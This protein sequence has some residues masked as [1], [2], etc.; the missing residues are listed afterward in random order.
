MH[1]KPGCSDYSRLVK[2]KHLT[3]IFETHC[4]IVKAITNKHAWAPKQYLYID[5]NAGPGEI[6]DYIGSPI[7]F[8]QV[9]KKLDVNYQVL[10]IEKDND[11]F[12]ALED[13][14]QPYRP[15]DNIHL[16]HNDHEVI[17][18]DPPFIKRESYG[19]L[20]S[21]PNGIK[22]FPSI[23]VLN[24]FIE[25]FPYID[26]LLH[27]GCTTFKRVDGA[28][29]TGIRANSYLLESK[30]RRYI[31]EPYTHQQWTFIFLTNYG[32]FDKK[33][34]NIGFYGHNEPRYSEIC[35]KIFFTAEE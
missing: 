24:Q 16:Y 19:L 20:Y 17:L 29:S 8:L 2:Q 5:A 1:K 18:P 10:F 9:A 12:L 23:K 22:G 31:R 25:R 26:I 3:N 33:F 30:K 15:D 14:V 6:D 34:R 32:G 27:C 28:C 35:E 4:S 13:R 11:S 21:D 7:N